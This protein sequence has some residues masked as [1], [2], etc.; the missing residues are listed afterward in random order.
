MNNIKHLFLALGLGLMTGSASAQSARAQKATISLPTIMCEKCKSTIEN[1]VWKQV[2]G[3]QFIEVNI[4]RKNAKVTFLPDRISLDNIKLFIADLG[5]KADNEEPDPE[6]IKLLS[7]E[8]KAHLLAPPP[9]GKG[10]VSDTLKA[11]PKRA[12]G[13]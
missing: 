7:K 3:V 13:R 4:K 10:V 6:A 11:A 12:G 5:Y 1:S 9:P 8:C 2:E